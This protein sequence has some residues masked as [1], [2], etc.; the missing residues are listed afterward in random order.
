MD[1]DDVLTVREAAELTGKSEQT[2]RKAILRRSLRGRRLG[3]ADHRSIWITTREDLESW[4]AGTVL[5][6]QRRDGSGRF[7]GPVIA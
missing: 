5:K 2:I 7:R 1:L 3:E 4:L 6:E